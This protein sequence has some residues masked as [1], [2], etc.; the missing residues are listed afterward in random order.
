LREHIQEV[1]EDITKDAVSYTL[2]EHDTKSGKVKFERE[3]E[4][5]EGF[6]A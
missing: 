5:V 3:Y 2:Q 1:E 6:M 4:W